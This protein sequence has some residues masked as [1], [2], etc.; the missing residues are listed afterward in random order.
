MVHVKGRNGDWCGVLWS[1][2]NVLAPDRVP[3]AVDLACCKCGGVRVVSGGGGDP[4][5]LLPPSHSPYALLSRKEGAS[6][7]CVTSDIFRFF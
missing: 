7:Q 4:P 6:W 1:E 2:D 3:W 5:P